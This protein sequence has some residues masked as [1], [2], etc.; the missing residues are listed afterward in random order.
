[1]AIDL[2][3]SHMLRGIRT[4]LLA[5][6]LAA[7]VPFVAVIGAGLWV[8]WR[9]EQAAALQRAIT[10]ARLLAAQ[11]DDHIGNL[12][13]LLTGLSLAVSVDPADTD[14][15]DALLIH[16]KSELPDFVSN[17]L[18]FAVDGTDI[19]LSWRRDGTRVNAAE[20][21]YFRRVL[22]GQRLAI[23]E[24]VH[25]LSTGEL[26][27]TIA[28]PVED[29]AGRLRAVL[30]VGTRL[31]HFHDALRL[32]HLPAGSIV[33]ILDERGVVISRTADATDWI[34]RDLGGVENVA[35]HLAAGEISEIMRWPDG[36]D[37]ITGSSTAHRAPWLVSVGLPTDTAFAAVASK[38]GWSAL[39]SI[40]ALMAAFAIAWVLSARIVQPLR[41]LR[42][43]ASVLAVGN[44]DHR[45]AVAT[46][47]EVGEL[48][49]TFNQMAASLERR[50]AE[51]ERAADEIRRTKDTLSAVIDASPVAIVCSDPDRRILLWN[52]AA[53]Q[54]FGYAAEEAVGHAT[55]LVPPEGAAYSQ[56]LFERAIAGET[57]RDVQL[58][59]MRKDGSLVDVRI[60]AARM[61][62]VDG[63][64]RGVAWAYEDITDRKRAEEQL[65]RL[66]HY[67]QLTG[68]P[69]RLTLQRELQ[70]LLD[71]DNGARS[72][73]V[74]LFDLDGFKDVNDTLGHS[75]G[76]RLLVEVGR[77]LAEIADHRGEV[78]RLGGDEFVVIVRDCGDPRVI[79]EIV[80]RML[81][82]LAEPFEIMDHV[83]HI[84]GSAGVAIA[85]GDGDNVDELI[86][87]AD[88]ALY[89]AKSDGGRTYRF[90][91]PVLRAQAHARREL[92]FE[93][94]RAFAH[95]E[96][97]L[98]FQ[99]Q[100]RLEDNAVVGAEAL[101]RWRHPVR[102]ILQP[103]AFLETLSESAIAH[104]VGTWIIRTACEKTQAWR[105]MGLPLSRIGVNLFPTHL[106]CPSL[107]HDIDQVLHRTGLPAELL[108]LEITENVALNYED[109][110][111][112][113]QQLH[114]RGVKLAF[115]D[116]GTGY[117]SLSYLTRFPLSRIKIDRCFVMRMT[118]DARDAAIVRSLIAM[119]H[120][121][122]LAVI[123]EGVETDAQADFLRTER[124]E[125]AQGFLF[126]KPLPADRFEEY[127]RTARIAQ[128]SP[129]AAQERAPARR[130]PI[131][132]PSRRKLRGA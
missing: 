93:L 37:R 27:I 129:I 68:L 24:V 119:A 72:T 56:A 17:V 38:L 103:G 107:I 16:V 79:G 1:M 89:R 86:A 4:Q 31:A 15:N 20:R 75:T 49:D 63:A 43:D 121:L 10:E 55:R 62:D 104:D 35:R 65:E 26:V 106:H 99:P 83:L 101:L 12:E 77:R 32:R 127:L 29:S 9:G 120:N 91:L 5:L 108:E 66:A 3:P 69:N 109:P 21:L 130:R 54:I 84:G 71:P 94:R 30:A 113:L 51:G 42:S 112:S 116:F 78:C 36:A 33:Q 118:E 81:Q 53:E 40:G 70:R 58:K 14:A 6:V 28:R 110:T 60:A 126:A 100:V 122:G 48:A 111:P 50:H 59:R 2:G 45:T 124:C 92:D 87:N 11:L 82:R 23:G 7:V 123:A 115:D 131:K 34:G 98:H 41:Q 128:Q 76:D 80:D 125:E 44:F 90:F 105:A 13:N 95:D 57:L 39:F 64:V 8:Q 117:A 19:G 52:H 96:F 85:P 114:E 74:A 97:E 22:A 132:L 47:D 88:L 18:L 73:A 61:H 102:G 25:S 67:D 46:P